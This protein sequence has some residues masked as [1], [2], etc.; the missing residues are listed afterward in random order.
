MSEENVE[1]VRRVMDAY[2]AGDYEA[3]FAELDPEVEFDVSIRPEGHVY[4]GHEGVAEALRT[5]TGTWEAYR[6]EV[7]EMIDAGD[8]VVVV[9]RQSGRGRGSGIPLAQRTFAVFTLSDGK[10]VRIAWFQT[11]RAALEAAGLQE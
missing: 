11:R 9:D 8:H 5:W 4:W 3:A 10:V 1:I 7:E 2:L 6:L